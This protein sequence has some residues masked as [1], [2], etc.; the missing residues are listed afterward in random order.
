MQVKQQSEDNGPEFE[1][2]LS[3]AFGAPLD[4]WRRLRPVTPSTC[5][6]TH[7]TSGIPSLI[8]RLTIPFAGLRVFLSH[9]SAPDLKSGGIMIQY[10][11]PV[12]LTLPWMTRTLFFFRG[13]SPTHLVNHTHLSGS[14]DLAWHLHRSNASLTMCGRTQDCPSQRVACQWPTTS[15]WAQNTSPPVHGELGGKFDTGKLLI[16]R[17]VTR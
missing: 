17:Y 10:Y 6:S 8:F 9:P 4:P 15:K 14:A 2:V 11:A 7:A 1:L 16:G 3:A 12:P 13:L 5:G